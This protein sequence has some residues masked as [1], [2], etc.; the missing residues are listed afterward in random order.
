MQTPITPDQPVP[1][2]VG[3]PKKPKKPSL[4]RAAKEKRNASRLPDLDGI[5]LFIRN[6]AAW[7]GL[8]F[9]YR[10]I[11][12]NH[13]VSPQAMAVMLAREKARL[14]AQAEESEFSGLSPRAV[15]CLGRLGIGS[16]TAARNMDNLET[17]L[18]AQRNC[19]GKTI[20][21][22][23]RWADQKPRKPTGTANE[24][25]KERM[26]PTSSTAAHARALRA[27]PARVTRTGRNGKAEVVFATGN[28]IA[29]APRPLDR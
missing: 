7:R 4:G 10:Q 11:A 28:P 24:K 26:Q 6:V 17:L 18:Q 19:G 20:R 8:G 3:H 14:N 21:E 2:S 1:E 15:N 29:L 27:M 13:G 12:K 25:D 23:I 16:R 5:P 9:S 22:I